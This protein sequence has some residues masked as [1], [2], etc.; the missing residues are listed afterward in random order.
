MNILGLITARGGS[1][2]IPKKNI[3]LLGKHPLIA[4][5]ITVAKKSVLG[6]HDIIVSTD[7]LEIAKVS[8]KYGAH[9]P[10]IR[11]AELASDTAKHVPVIQHAVKYMEDKKGRKYDYIILLQPT[12]PF[13]LPEDIN[14]TLDALIRADADSA[15]SLVEIKDNHPIKAKI[16]ENGLVKP[17]FSEYPEIEGTR[18]QDLRTAYKRSGAVYIMKRDLVVEQSLLYGNVIAGHVVPED[19]SIDIDNLK[20]WVVAEYMLKNLTDRNIIFF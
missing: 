3:K 1:K 4:Y 13:R 14:N 19:R 8:K 18:R 9:V 10:F 12:S 15:V 17:F 2:G 20:D 11:P 5:T 6:N 16:F 7:D